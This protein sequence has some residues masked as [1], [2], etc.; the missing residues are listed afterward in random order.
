MLGLAVL[1][2]EADRVWTLFRT[3][4]ALAH[5]PEACLGLDELAG[6]YWR[7]AR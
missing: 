2:T 7:E 6:A 3:E 5:I 1:V 4:A